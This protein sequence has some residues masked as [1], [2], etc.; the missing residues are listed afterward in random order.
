MHLWRARVLNLR[1]TFFF[2]SYCQF[3]FAVLFFLLRLPFFAISLLLLFLCLCKIV[4]G[5]RK[6]ERVAMTSLMLTIMVER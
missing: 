5:Q 6:R 2:H 4:I 1:V 3:S